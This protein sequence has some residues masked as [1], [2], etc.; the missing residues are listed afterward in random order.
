MKKLFISGLVIFI[1]F[2]IGGTITW[3][4]FDK[5]KYE[6][7]S[8][9]KT[10]NSRFEHVSINTVTSNIRFIPGKKFAV[11]FRGDNDVYVSNKGKTLKVTE[12]R[13]TDRGYGLNFNPF[14][15][16]KKSL[17]I[18]LPDNKIK[19]LT[20]ESVIGTIHFNN[21]KSQNTSILSNSMFQ[22]RNSHFDNL[23]YESSNGTANIQDS[24]I[25][26]GNLKLDNGDITVKNS[27]CNNSTF[28]IDKGNILMKNM[29]S[30]NDIKA[31][32][33]KGDV[34]YHF[35]EKPRNTL[36]KLHPGHGSKSIKNKN[37]KNGKV[38]NSKNILEFYTVDG[39]ITVS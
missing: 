23:N 37:F 15:K 12:K 34:D 19:Y 3:F 30:S 2:F 16:N 31:S 29:K 4:T 27:K 5:H 28:L 18:V 13:A 24:V 25:K 11:H 36:L 33:K 21:I 39:D 8:Y 26:K 6:N 7:Q 17:T 10:F 22:V 35:D 9:H 14:H 1:S 20:A 32:I 38:G